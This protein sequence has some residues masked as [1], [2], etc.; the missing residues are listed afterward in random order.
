MCDFFIFVTEQDT[1]LGRVLYTFLSNHLDHYW[2]VF[3]FYI[4]L[5]YKKRTISHLSPYQP[6]CQCKCCIVALLLLIK[7]NGSQ[8]CVSI[9]FTYLWPLVW[10]DNDCNTHKIIGHKVLICPLSLSYIRHWRAHRRTL[11]TLVGGHKAQLFY[12]HIN[13]FIVYL[14]SSVK[15]MG[16]V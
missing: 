9:I 14:H 11:Q 3:I 7:I 12:S 8:V 10:K 5:K 13:T 15:K 6:L 2:L 4:G 1:G 16:E